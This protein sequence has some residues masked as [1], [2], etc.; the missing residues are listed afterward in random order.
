MAPSMPP[1][2]VSLPKLALV[3]P[4]PPLALPAGASRP[5]SAAPPSAGTELRAPAPASAPWSSRLSLP[6][7]F[8]ARRVSSLSARTESAVE[9]G[10]SPALGPAAPA[11]AASGLGLPA[12]RA[13]VCLCAFSSVFSLPFGCFLPVSVAARPA[14]ARA[15][16]CA[17]VSVPPPRGA[18]SAHRLPLPPPLDPVLTC[19]APGAPRAS[20]PRRRTPGRARARGRQDGAG[21]PAFSSVLLLRDVSRLWRFIPSLGCLFFFC[22]L[23]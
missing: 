10:A 15:A 4:C 13:V 11:R 8:G 18:A 9:G 12:R 5:P 7:V 3:Q 23:L 1:R 6:R 22:H 20:L 19:A 2:R 14:A 16:A 17:A 21:E